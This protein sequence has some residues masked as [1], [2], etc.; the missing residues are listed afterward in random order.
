MSYFS[1][2]KKESDKALELFELVDF[3]PYGAMILSN[4]DDKILVR[5]VN[6]DFYKL[7]GQKGFAVKKYP[8]KLKKT[9]PELWNS[10]EIKDA[11]S[12]TIKDHKVREVNFSVNVDN[13]TISILVTISLVVESYLLL[14]IENDNNAASNRHIINLATEHINLI[15]E[16][17]SKLSEDID[18]KG[19]L[20]HACD[21]LKDI[22][23]LYFTDA[24][25]RSEHSVIDVTSP[26]YT[27]LSSNVMSIMEKT[28][29]VSYKDLKAPVVPDTIWEKLYING[30]YIVSDGDK[31]PVVLADFVSRDQI[32]IRKMAPLV[33]KLSKINF[34]MMVPMRLG[35][36][37]IGHI[38]FDAEKRLSIQ[39]IDA[40][41]IVVDKVASVVI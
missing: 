27:N 36:K 34:V 19:I 28:A 9:F 23:N 30:E 26:V 39:D 16:L 12:K 10:D 13:S 21:R 41:K 4:A 24:W 37:V 29:G 40:I 7:L 18:V 8:S 31:L 1:F 33:A 17:T 11:L 6:D 3:L 38:G 22:H 25:L 32:A 5:A 2:G 14:I 15:G 35:K 20:K